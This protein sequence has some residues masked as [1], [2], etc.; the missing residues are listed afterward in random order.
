M[1]L[2][3]DDWHLWQQDYSGGI[4]SVTSS[5][6]IDVEKDL[7]YDKKRGNVFYA[8]VEQPL[9]LLPN[10]KV[11]CTEMETSGTGTLQREIELNN[12]PFANGTSFSY[13]LD[14]SHTDITG[15]WQPLQNWVTFGLAFTVCIYDSR[16]I[17]RSRINSGV[18]VKKEVE[19]R[20]PMAYRKASLQIPNTNFSVAAELQVSGYDGSS[21]VDAQLQIAYESIFGFGAVLGWRSFQLDQENIDDVDADISVSGGYPGVTYQF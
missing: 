2:I 3:L 19:Q 7:R 4:N 6:I 5:M 15:Y 17:V 18:R 16:I 1:Q 12:T 21:L 9:P 20:L 8:A 14:L 13:S 11:Q 10:F